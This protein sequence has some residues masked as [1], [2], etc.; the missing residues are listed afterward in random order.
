MSLLE[1]ARVAHLITIASEM[2]AALDQYYSKHHHEHG[3]D[4]RTNLALA[5]SFAASDYIQAQRARTR[6]TAN[7]SRAFEKVDAVVTPTTGCT[8]P[9]IAPDALGGESDL[10]KLME[11]M[12][13]TSI[14]NLTGHP[15]I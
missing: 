1:A 7:L 13:F 6:T 10:T 12:R 15:A 5:R 4:V 11:I 2:L 3:L 14:A 9:A 8:A